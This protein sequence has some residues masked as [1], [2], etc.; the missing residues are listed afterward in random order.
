MLRLYLS[1]LIWSLSEV[2]PVYSE[3]VAPTSLC[4]PSWLLFGERC[5]AFFPVWSSWSTART[6]CSQTGGT[7]MLL[8]TPEEKKIINQLTNTSTPVW[9][10]GYKNDS[11]LWSNDDNWTDQAD[12]KTN[13]CRAC[14][15]MTPKSK[16]IH[17]GGSQCS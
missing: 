11:Q 10:G 17:S 5:Y 9:L 6:L 14:M 12:G 2:S 3:V 7:L 13:G 1:L 15:Q 8:N 4:Q 16:V